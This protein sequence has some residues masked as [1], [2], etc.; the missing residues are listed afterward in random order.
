V[1]ISVVNDL[2]TQKTEGRERSRQHSRKKE[3][4]NEGLDESKP[5]TVLKRSKVSLPMIKDAEEV[6]T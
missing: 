3:K 5:I 1:S 6:K 2:K 4:Q